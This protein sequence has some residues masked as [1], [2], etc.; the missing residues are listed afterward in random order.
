[1]HRVDSKDSFGLHTEFRCGFARVGFT[2]VLQ[3]SLIDIEVN[4]RLPE[5]LWRKPAEYVDDNFKSIVLSLL[6]LLLSFI[7]ITFIVVVVI[8]IV[9]IIIIIAIIIIIII[10]KIAE[11]FFKNILLSLLL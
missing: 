10:R 4:I 5:L 8:V 7:I 11:L 2:H 6:L 3:A 1:M 9:I